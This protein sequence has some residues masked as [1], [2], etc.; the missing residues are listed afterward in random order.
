M[1]GAY[2]SIIIEFR[3]VVKGF[4][5]YIYVMCANFGKIIIFL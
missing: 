1:I 5:S 4:L 2:I 3:A